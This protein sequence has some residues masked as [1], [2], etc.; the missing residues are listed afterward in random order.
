M[1]LRARVVALIGLVLL[2]ATVVGALVVGS[3][4][5]LALH[6]ELASGL[7]GGRATVGNALAIWAPG[8]TFTSVADNVKIT[9]NSFDAATGAANVTVRPATDPGEYSFALDNY[10]VTEGGPQITVSVTRTA[11]FTTAG[12]VVWTTANGTA[13]SGTDFGV[14]GN[15]GN[16]TGT[17]TWAAGTG[18]SK[19]FTIGAPTSIIPFIP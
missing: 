1:S 13:I 7:A 8:S 10:T 19:T 11:P 9:V 3:Q 2:L 6:A 16:R 12:S 15:A 14:A 17:L 4:S 5:R 18:G